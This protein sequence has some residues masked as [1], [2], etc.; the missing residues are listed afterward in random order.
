MGQSFIL[1][2]YFM[3]SLRTDGSPGIPPR[4]HPHLLF[5]DLHKML[6]I[7][8]SDLGGDLIDAPVVVQK[9]LLGMLDAESGKI[10]ENPIPSTSA[11]SLEI[12]GG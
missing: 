4:G 3:P 8:I 6:H 2:C 1:V 10:F 7:L 5:K 11:N 12:G 9:G